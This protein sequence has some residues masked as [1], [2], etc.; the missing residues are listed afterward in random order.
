MVN[1]AVEVIAL[2]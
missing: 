1:D 2:Q